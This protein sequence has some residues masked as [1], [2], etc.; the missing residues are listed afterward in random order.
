MKYYDQDCR[1]DKLLCAAVRS[2]SDFQVR[3]RWTP[4]LGSEETTQYPA[5]SYR[6]KQG[7][8]LHNR[9]R[10]L[11]QRLFGD[12]VISGARERGPRRE[13]AE[14]APGPVEGLHK[15]GCGP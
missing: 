2:D 14:R 7:V 11:S 4:Q 3:M 1:H 15:V 10:R 6:T 12:W 5:I 9:E 8:Y 13:Q